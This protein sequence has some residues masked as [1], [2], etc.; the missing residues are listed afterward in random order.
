MIIFALSIVIYNLS[1]TEFAF[2]DGLK[3]AE[4]A[5]S[6]ICGHI[7]GSLGALLMA[8]AG[9]GAVVSAAFGNLKAS[10]GLIVV[11]VGAFTVSS[12]LS[13]YF[14]AAAAFCK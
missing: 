12:F 7:M 10:Y 13:L 6:E 5:I 11:G 2:A 1:I 9:V 8:T 3:S 4:F 14:P